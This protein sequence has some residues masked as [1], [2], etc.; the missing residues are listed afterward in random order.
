MAQNF[1]PLPGA[2]QVCAGMGLDVDAWHA[3]GRA[4]LDRGR[5][6]AA[7]VVF[8]PILAVNAQ[9]S[10]AWCFLGTISEARLQYHEAEAAYRRAIVADARLPQLRF[11]LFEIGN[12][13]NVRFK[14]HS[15]R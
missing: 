9:N 11:N 4:L 15:R 12:T 2:S 14:S 7:D 1:V 3:N 10:V 8:R 5:L 6:D 13:Q